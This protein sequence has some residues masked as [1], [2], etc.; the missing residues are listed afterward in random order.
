MRSRTYSLLVPCPNVPTPMDTT[1]GTAGGCWFRQCPRSQRG[2][3]VAR[4]SR[5]SLPTGL[6][7]SMD[8]HVRSWCENP[9]PLPA[10]PIPEASQRLGMG[11]RDQAR[12]LSADCPKR[13]QSSQAIHPTGLRL[14]R[15]ISPDSRILLPA[16]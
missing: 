14:E 13:R 16:V 7:A 6:V 8:R 3:P 12:R 9:A 5:R 15:E 2:E 10:D 1:V 4:D 11:P